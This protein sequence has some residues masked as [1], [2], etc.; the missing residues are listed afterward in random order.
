M[1]TKVKRDL[2]DESKRSLVK[3]ELF[4][5]FFPKRM[6]EGLKNRVYWYYLKL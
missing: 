3:V 6:A 5:N 1:E 2:H 4:K